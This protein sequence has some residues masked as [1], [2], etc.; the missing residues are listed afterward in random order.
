MAFDASKARHKFQ[1]EGVKTL[2]NAV[3][4][5]SGHYSHCIC[6]FKSDAMQ[7]NL[8]SIT[9]F[10]LKQVSETASIRAPTSKVTLIDPSV[11]L[12]LSTIEVPVD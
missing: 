4:D 9:Y 6:S 7:T 1:K 12:L 3:G 5:V 2:P 11:S 10:V 8:R